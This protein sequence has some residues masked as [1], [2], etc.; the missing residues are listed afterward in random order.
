MEYHHISILKNYG[1]KIQYKQLYPIIKKDQ[2]TQTPE[3][4]NEDQLNF[5]HKIKQ[6]LK[7][8][9]KGCFNKFIY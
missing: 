4:N 2:K 5:Q 1:I 3:L 9:F 8:T 6:P 7:L